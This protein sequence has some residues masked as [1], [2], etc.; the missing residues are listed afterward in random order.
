MKPF[1]PNDPVIWVDEQTNDI[2]G[3][4]TEVSKGG[5]RIHWDCPSPY[6][7]EKNEM[8]YPDEYLS[9]KTASD[10]PVIRL[11]MSRIREEKIST[12]LQ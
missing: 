9:L 2:T 11:D 3:I 5:F 12:I 4:I 8:F 7:D 10:N 6:G 1:K